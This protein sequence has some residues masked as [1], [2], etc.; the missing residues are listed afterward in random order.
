MNI[1]DILLTQK[2]ELE[3]RCQENYVPRNIEYQR[4]DND[5]INVIT[6]PRR[7]GKSFLAMHMIKKTGQYGY[8]NFDDERLTEL[9]DYDQL[10]A[11]LDNVYNKPKHLLLDEIQNLPKWELFLNRL[12]RRGLRMIVTGSNAHLLSSEL[13]THLTGR[14]LSTVLFPFSFAEYVSAIGEELTDLEK[15]EKLNLYAIQGG[16]PETFLKDVPVNDYLST[17]MDSILYKD[18]AKRFRIRSLA[19]IE[20]LARYLLAN[21]ASEY[22]FNTLTKVTKCRSVHT[23]EKYLGY[24][25]RAFLFFSLPRFS[26]KMS[27]QINANR[28]I[29][30]IDNG[31]ISAKGFQFSANSGKI[32][33]NLVAV[34]LKKMVLEGKLELSFWKN[35][36]HEEVDFII[37]K[38][39]K[40][41]ELIQV[42][43]DASRPET[44]NREM[45]A[46]INASREL[47]C[48][49][50]MVLTN[51]LEIE[52]D[53]EWFG[54][55]GKVRFYP[56]WK[57][58]ME[59]G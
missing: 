52:E 41:T 45:R 21:I 54:K 30:C 58:L 43:F 20:D 13:A 39:T 18:I 27:E 55:K 51:D 16:L 40:V 24:L 6:G 29:Y 2:R 4:R 33:E 32:M 15:T 23:V 5:L 17:L 8:I 47:K 34:K 31:F 38:G 7:S 57:W 44:R 12:Q 25:E 19:G 48:R 59:Q 42:C 37:K 1:S 50:L 49:K 3:K 46:L 35:A 11:A 14:H 53:L 56:L 28:K 22:S 10:L 36:R 9:S 26:W